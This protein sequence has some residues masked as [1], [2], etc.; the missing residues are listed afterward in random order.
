MTDFLHQP[1]LLDEVLVNL[2]IKADG[3]YID[4]TFGRG[5]HSRVIL[6]RLDQQGQLLLLDKDPEA[7]TIAKTEFGPDPRIKIAAGSFTQI[8]ET[9]QKLG[10]LGQVDG[11]LLDLGVSSPQLDNPERGFSFLR[12]GPLD[13][14]MDTTQ[15]RDARWWIQH[16]PEREMSRVFFEFGEERYANRIAKAICQAREQTAIT[17][18]T[19]LADIVAKAHPRWERHKH[20][21]TRVFQAIRIAVNAE[22]EEIKTALLNCLEVLAI[23]GRL[24]VISFHSLEDRIVKNFMT[25]FATHTQLPRGLAIP[26]VELEKNLRIKRVNGAIKPS[27][28]EIS[29]NPRARSATLRTME[30]LK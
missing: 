30:K 7:I 12:E 20:P 10:W 27:E 11:I 15:S 24:V 23:G 26:Q 2:N 17:S 19:Q 5:G 29:L 8:Y 4:G 1:V 9:A 14:R 13:M 3:I 22:L 16:T 21:A 6:Q 25:Q 18:T 28:R